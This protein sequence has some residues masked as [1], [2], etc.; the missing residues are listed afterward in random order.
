ML[1]CKNTGS[2]HKYSRAELG[3]KFSIRVPCTIHAGELL[4]K[5]EE[6]LYFSDR[7]GPV[8]GPAL[9]LDRLVLLLRLDLPQRRLEV[10]LEVLQTRPNSQSK[11]TPLRRKLATVCTHLVCFI[12]RAD[13]SV[14]RHRG[15]G[16]RDAARQVRRRLALLAVLPAPRRL[17]LDE[18]LS[19]YLRV[20]VDDLR[21]RQSLPRAP[22]A[23]DLLSRIGILEWL[24]GLLAS[25]QL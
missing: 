18:L 17:L 8:V 24:V 19:R 3:R 16:S 25:D 13:R 6:L 21:L 15:L 5:D 11:L 14:V 7:L 1:V 10:R 2:Y 9:L 22:T 23:L 12:A 20:R 4:I